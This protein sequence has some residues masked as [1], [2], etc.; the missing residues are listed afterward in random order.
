LLARYDDLRLQAL[1]QRLEGLPSRRR[2]A[3]VNA[4]RE[5]VPA[6]TAHPEP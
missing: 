6:T 3:V 1:H 4:L 5:L 2:T